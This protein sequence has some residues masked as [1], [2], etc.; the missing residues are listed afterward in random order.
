MELQSAR[1]Y[2]GFPVFG[3]TKTLSRISKPMRLGLLRN[4]VFRLVSANWSA[5]ILA[6]KLVK[7]SYSRR[8]K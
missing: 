1:I 6:L 2:A 3:E 4:F 8:R 5:N 7:L